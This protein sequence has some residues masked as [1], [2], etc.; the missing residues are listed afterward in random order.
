M[1]AT[2]PHA[3]QDERMNHERPQALLSDPGHVSPGAW[4]IPQRSRFV[5][6]LIEAEQALRASQE[7]FR[8]ARQIQQG[9]FP[10]SAPAL[11][12][13]ELAGASFP[14]GAT[15]GDYFDYFP[16]GEGGIALVAGDA[17]GHGVGPALLSAST[18]AYLRALALTHADAGT[19]LTS[20]NNLLSG[21]LGDCHFVTVLLAQFD[22]RRRQLT[23]ASAGHQT[24]YVLNSLGAMKACLTSTGYPLG[25]NARAPVPLGPELSLH[26]G[27]LVLL[28]TDGIADALSAAGQAFGIDRMLDVVRAHRRQPARQI[29]DTLYQAVRAHCQP[30]RPHDDIT[31]VILKVGAEPA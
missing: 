21:D 24:G 30:G 17:S 20:A 22:P 1:E 18:R 16:L 15:S 27:D 29:I 25:V 28:P 3:G 11:P 13:C 26:P 12:G 5:S 9:L 23:H 19:I 14:A 4:T 2:N 7:E 8:V 10:R 31:A 6:R